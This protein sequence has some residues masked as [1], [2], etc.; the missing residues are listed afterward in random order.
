MVKHQS[1]DYWVYAN[2]GMD[3]RLWSLVISGGKVRPD[4]ED[5]TSFVAEFD[6]LAVELIISFTGGG[7]I[8]VLCRQFDTVIKPLSS[9][10]TPTA[11][12]NNFATW[13]TDSLRALGPSVTRDTLLLSLW[14]IISTLFFL[15]ALAQIS[16]YRCSLISRVWE[17]YLLKTVS[18]FPVSVLNT[19][20]TFCLSL[21][22]SYLI[23]F[24]AV[25]Y[26]I[27]IYHFLLLALLTVP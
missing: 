2:A 12:N 23:S 15:Q 21:C 22:Y 6:V 10:F 24:Q 13:V 19:I 20:L 8:L 27:L 26:Y 5:V 25:W 11:A 18:W 7:E 4:K 16:L 3:G 1:L 14:W 9:L 17:T